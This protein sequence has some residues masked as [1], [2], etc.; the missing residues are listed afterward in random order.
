MD[1]KV[2]LKITLLSYLSSSDSYLSSNLGTYWKYYYSDFKMYCSQNSGLIDAVA[3]LA[4]E[5]CEKL[6]FELQVATYSLTIVR[7][8]QP[9][10]AS[11]GSC[12]RKKVTCLTKA[13]K[14]TSGQDYL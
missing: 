13:R 9:G 4:A 14:D 5:P 7:L 3:V 12:C 6:Q 8:Q 1:K 10:T 11:I 2:A